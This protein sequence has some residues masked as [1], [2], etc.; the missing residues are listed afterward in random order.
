MIWEHDFTQIF[1][2]SSENKVFLTV[3][4]NSM[5]FAPGHYH[6]LVFVVAQCMIFDRNQ[7]NQYLIYV[8]KTGE[9]PLFFCFNL[10][11]W[12]KYFLHSVATEK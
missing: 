7:P 1:V 3:G 6:H 2:D 8:I 10:L 4:W 9:R 11:F 12:R 5:S